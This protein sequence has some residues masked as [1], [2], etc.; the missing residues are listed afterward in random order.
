MGVVLLLNKGSQRRIEAIIERGAYSVGNLG[1]QILS[2]KLKF[3]SKYL[4]L[5]NAVCVHMCV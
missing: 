5:F 3:I 2:S 1:A 4:C